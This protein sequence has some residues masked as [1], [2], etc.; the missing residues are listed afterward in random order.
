MYVTRGDK[1]SEKEWLVYLL[2]IGLL[3][4]IGTNHK[5]V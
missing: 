4:S 5:F 1:S 3:F 2:L